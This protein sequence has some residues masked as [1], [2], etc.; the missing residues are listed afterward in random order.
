MLSSSISRPDAL[1]PSRL[2]IARMTFWVVLT[3]AVAGLL[4]YMLWMPGKSYSGALRPLSAEEAQLRDNLRRHVVAVASR[5]H[6]ALE[7]VNL[8]AAARYIENTLTGLG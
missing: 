2:R 3:A 1:P 7:R 5:E 4:W 6:H 8:E